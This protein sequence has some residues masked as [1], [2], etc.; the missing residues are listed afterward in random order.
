MENLRLYFIGVG[1]NR[2]LS[3]KIRES[4]SIVII[5]YLPHEECMKAINSAD[6][7]LNLG[8]SQPYM[9]PS[10]LFEYFIISIL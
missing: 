10:K 9:M 4:D 3:S 7:L 2:Y 6:F 5:P 1:D 8:N